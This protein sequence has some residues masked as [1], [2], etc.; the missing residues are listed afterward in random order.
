MRAHGV[1]LFRDSVP[2][3]ML[4]CNI[5]KVEAAGSRMERSLRT[6]PGFGGPSEARVKLR[7]S[8]APGRR[9]RSVRW[10]VGPPTDVTALYAGARLPEHPLYARGYTS[11]GCD[12]CTRAMLP[13]EDERAGRWW[14]EE[15]AAKGMRSALQRR[16]TGRTHG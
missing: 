10:P 3:R 14:W 12:P 9:L 1:D 15:D 6:S 8:T 7:S 2:Q 4:C 5:R 11:I 13:G 16:W